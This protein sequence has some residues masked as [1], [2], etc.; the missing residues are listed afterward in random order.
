MSYKPSLFHLYWLLIALNTTGCDTF[1]SENVCESRNCEQFEIHLNNNFDDD[2]VRIEI[3]GK[4]VFNKRI[5]TD[6]IWSLAEIIELERPEGTHHINVVVNGNEEGKR[7][8][9]LDDMLYIHVR[10]YHEPLP[11]SNI[12]E[13]IKIDFNTEPPMYD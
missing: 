6:Y 12:S 11:D 2:Y 5:T 4:P 7:S 3:D 9:E 1:Y 8:F 10:Y 13:G